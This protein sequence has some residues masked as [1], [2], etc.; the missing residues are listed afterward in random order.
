MVMPADNHVHTEF[1]WD[2][3][4][5]SMRA[6]CE[7]AVAI[8]LPS[9]AFTEHVDMTEWAIRDPRA[10]ADPV[11]Q[12]G[13]DRPGCF[14]APPV[15]LEGYF[16]S[17]DRCRR[18]FPDLRVLTGLEIG[19]PH[20]FAEQTA[21]LLA[22][23]PFERVLGSLH[24]TTIDDEHRL[25]DEW[26]PENT[27]EEHDASA[28]RAY[29]AEAIDL[30][31]SSDVFEVFAHIDYVSRQIER[32]GRTHDPVDFE[33]E[34][35]ETLRAIRG[36]DRVLEINTRRPLDEVILRWWYD[37]GGAAV[38]FGSDAH[39]GAK[40]GHGFRSA[41]AMAQSIGFGPQDDPLDFWRR[42][43]S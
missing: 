43:P 10:A 19:E 22:S 21:S 15:D 4:H 14:T 38:S 39:E 35:R 32:V 40:V 34:Y 27:T 8:G 42:I 12:Q 31:R 26:Y 18:E 29:L 37:A 1:S 7:R 36:A 17:V 33:D 2:A 30:V 5:G 9:I 23:G 41:A 6:S 20:W 25:I 16:E 13:L 11:I 28:L 3:R 24:T